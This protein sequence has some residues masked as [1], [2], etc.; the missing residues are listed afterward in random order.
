MR[1]V[2]SRLLKIRLL[3]RILH[4]VVKR[5]ALLRPKLRK[6]A[7]VVLNDQTIPFMCLP[8]SAESLHLIK[9]RINLLQKQMK[10]GS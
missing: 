1:A 8:G 10:F 9:I 2:L 3:Q 6:D 4:L 7:E 5:R